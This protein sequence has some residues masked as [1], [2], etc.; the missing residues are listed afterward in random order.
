MFLVISDG[1]SR[2]RE[3]SQFLDACGAEYMFHFS[4]FS[5]AGE[6]LSLIHI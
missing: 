4:K 2:T 3:V 6:F 1:G 5:D